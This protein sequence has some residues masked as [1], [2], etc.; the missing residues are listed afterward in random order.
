MPEVLTLAR[1]GY[2]KETV[3]EDIRERLSQWM[4]TYGLRGKLG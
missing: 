4:L 3:D 2:T 1:V